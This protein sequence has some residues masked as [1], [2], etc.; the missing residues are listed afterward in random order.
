MLPYPSIREA[1]TCELGSPACSINKRTHP[2]YLVLRG[3]YA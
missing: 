2:L 3:G 1:L